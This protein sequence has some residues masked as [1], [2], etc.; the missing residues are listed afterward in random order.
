MRPACSPSS[1]TFSSSSAVSSPTAPSS[2]ARP[3]APTRPRIASSRAIERTVCA[4]ASATSRASPLS[5]TSL[6][7]SLRDERTQLVL[8]AAGLD[9]AVDAALLRCV[10][11]PPPTPGAQVL[12]RGGRARARSAADRR[13]AL[14]VE[15]VVRQIALAHVVPDLVLGP[16]G[17]RI[18]LH[19]RA[20]VGVDLDLA[21]VAA[22]RPL[23][24]AQTGHPPVQ[25][26]EV[27]RQRQHLA[28]VA[29]EHAVLD[30]LVE[31]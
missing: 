22:C 8:Q 25:R 3:T 29:A 13:V 19:D 1:S 9:G 2:P 12:S 18:E 27:R 15:A 21:D 16:L 20:V 5:V 10:R 24:A 23:V 11:L 26:G 4:S 17:E 31:E 7:P 14:V 28:Y 30:A 6:I